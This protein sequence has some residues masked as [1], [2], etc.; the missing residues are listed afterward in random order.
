[1][2]P[3]PPA[4]AHKQTF[5]LRYGKRALDLVAGVPAL[6]FALPLL[7]AIALV[8][9]V[10]SGRP[11]FF[12]QERVGLNGRRFGLIKFRTMIPN[13]VSYGAGYYLEENDKRITWAGRWLRLTS[14][15]E[16]PQLLNVVK[17]DISLVGPRP[18]L[19]LI[20]E[21]YAQSYQQILTVKPG[22]TGLAAIRGRNLL[23]RSQ[24]LALDRQYV[25]KV[26]LGTDVR[27]LLGTIPVVLLRRGSSNA[28][29]EEFIEDAPTDGVLEDAGAHR[30]HR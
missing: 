26:S 22:L 11:V 5:Y 2:P 12:V 18:N 9:L 19:P 24:M 15:D 13:A 17:G 21:R 16:L 23:R 20:V 6:I 29:S 4:Q 30:A 1:M 14:L 27:I 10:T 3:S 25:S 8:V 7:V 28:V